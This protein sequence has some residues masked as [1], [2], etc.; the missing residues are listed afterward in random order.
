MAQARQKEDY[1]KDTE[2]RT[3]NEKDIVLLK[4]MHKQKGKFYQR[5]EGPYVIV[6][7]LSDLNYLI[8]H[9]HDNYTVVVH[10]NR[11]RKW[12]GRVTAKDLTS[13]EVNPVTNQQ[14]QV[15]L[16][17]TDIINNTDVNNPAHFV[18]DIHDILI[19]AP[20][21]NTSIRPETSSDRN[22]SATDVTTTRRPEEIVQTETVDNLI[23]ENAV[24]AEGQ[25]ALNESATEVNIESVVNADNVANVAQT[26]A[27]ESESLQTAQPVDPPAKRKRGRPRKDERRMT[28]APPPVETTPT[29]PAHQHSLRRQTRQPARYQAGNY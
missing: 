23:D 28:E 27:A 12:H 4:I 5:F 6:K 14:A 24:N 2:S 1:D 19:H 16:E 7:K 8:R 21:E 3:F 17:T 26:V 11:L 9:K 13:I 22:A 18:V 25:I 15:H 29:L 10:I 20:K